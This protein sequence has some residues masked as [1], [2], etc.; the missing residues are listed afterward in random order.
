MG[1]ARKGDSVMSL[2]TSVIVGFF[3]LVFAIILQVGIIVI[4]AENVKRAKTKSGVELF[5][6]CVP[7][8]EKVSIVTVAN[9]VLQLVLFAAPAFLIHLIGCAAKYIL[10]H[11]VR[12]L[13][14]ICINKTVEQNSKKADQ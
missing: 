13:D 7:T 2:I 4:I 11:G 8:M 10:I 6:D 1:G 3:E 5:M 9:W 14:N 12:F